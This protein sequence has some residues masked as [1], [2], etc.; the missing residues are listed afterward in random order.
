MSY[1][2]PGWE[3]LVTAQGDG[4]ALT[5]AAAASCIPASAKFVLPANFF[6]W[7]GQQLIV[8]AW[9]RISCAVTTPGTGRYDLRFGAGGTVVADSLAMNLNVVAKTN[10]SWYL[11]MLLTCR[12]IGPAANL[13]QGILWASEAG[14]ASPLPT[15]GG[16]AQFLN[17]YNSAPVVGANFDSTAAQIVDLFFTQTVATGSMT[18]HQYSLI[19]PN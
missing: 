3:T 6:K 18:L 11:K 4:T 10:V 13:H 15:V 5:A 2:A 19:S 17:P 12:A 8:E 14:I 9:G 1:G 16:S 7:V